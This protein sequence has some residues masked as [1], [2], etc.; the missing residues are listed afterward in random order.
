MENAK[1]KIKYP[2]LKGFERGNG[3][4]SV[5]CPECNKFHSHGIGEGHRT[6]HCGIINKN[7][8]IIKSPYDEHGYIIKVFTKAELKQYLPFIK[9]TLKGVF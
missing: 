5:W 1:E 2:I 7:N 3:F 8:Q 9:K 4:I 6:A